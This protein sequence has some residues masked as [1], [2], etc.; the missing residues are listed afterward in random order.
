MLCNDYLMNRICIFLIHV[1]YR[2][3]KIGSGVYSRLAV[4]FAIFM[5]LPVGL[6]SLTR[7][8]L[9]QRYWLVKTSLE[10]FLKGRRAS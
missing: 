10:S 5:L 3:Q 6:L 7:V 9:V 8:T 1:V 4:R 2:G